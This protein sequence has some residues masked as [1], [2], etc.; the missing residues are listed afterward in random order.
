MPPL[1]ITPKALAE[2][3]MSFHSNL[4]AGAKNLTKMQPLPCGVTPHEVVLQRGKL[5]LL[6][7]KGDKPTSQSIPL[8]IVYSLI[9]RPYMADIQHG[10]SM[11]QGLLDRGQDVYLIDWGYPDANDRYTSLDDYINGAINACVNELCRRLR[12][13]QINLLGICQG[14]V[15][16][17]CYSALHTDK[18]RNLITMVTPVDFHT[19]DNMLTHWAKGIDVDQLVD[20][21][22]NIPGPMLNTLFMSMRP[23][24]QMG[25]KY[26]ALVDIMDD[27]NSLRDFMLLEQWL[28]D[29]PDQAGEAFRQFVKEIVQQN[30]LVTGG[31]KVGGKTVDLNNI[32]MPILNI[33]AQYDHLVPPAS[34]MALKKRV[35]SQDYSEILYKGGHIGPFVSVKAQKTIPQS[36]GSWL[37]SR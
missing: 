8:L 2:E 16:G 4:L 24:R 14:G 33:Y 21:L 17:L 3:V 6:H 13:D 20:V 26:V 19:S 29:G 23:Y 36:I 37:S 35:S 1:Q 32:A 15:L 27:P 7:Y 28:F 12:V 34:A 10:Q 5:R 9:N 31:L 30:K 18:I 25:Q 11:V 22:G